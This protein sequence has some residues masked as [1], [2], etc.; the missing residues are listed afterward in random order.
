[1]KQITLKIG[2]AVLRVAAT[3]EVAVAEPLSAAIA[4]VFTGFGFSAA[5]AMLEGMGESDPPTIETVIAALPAFEWP[6]AA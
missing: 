1:M 6:E 2:I 4:T 5:T 3:C